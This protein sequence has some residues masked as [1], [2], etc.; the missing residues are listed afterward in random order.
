MNQL[1]RE[2]NPR[3][4]VA[5]MW[6]GLWTQD[7]VLA[8]E[9]WLA[10][11]ASFALSTVQA[12]LRRPILYA[13]TGLLAAAASYGAVVSNVHSREQ[14]TRSVRV[15]QEAFANALD[16]YKRENGRLPA[17]LEDLVPKH[18]RAMRSDPWGNPYAYYRGEGGSAVVSAGPDGKLGTGDDIVA[19]EGEI[20]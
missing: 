2:Q 7:L 5:R 6:I 13:S 3:A 8:A 14:L 9:Y 16:L 20:K 19:N 18:L 1:T 10:R 11:G 15:D 12:W 17:R 4:A